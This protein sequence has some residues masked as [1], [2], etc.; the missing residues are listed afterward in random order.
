MS[1]AMLWVLTPLLLVASIVYAIVY[2]QNTRANAKINKALGK[3]SNDVYIA[4]IVIAS[5]FGLLLGGL[6]L[7]A[8]LG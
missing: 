4:S 8:V 1:L 5:V 6:I 2:K 3:Y 7:N